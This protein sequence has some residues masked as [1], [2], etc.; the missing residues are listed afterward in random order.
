M[1]FIPNAC[2]MLKLAHNA[3][4]DLKV[5]RDDAKQEIKWKHFQML[6][7]IQEE[8]G[9]KICYKLSK[10]H[11]QFQQHKM[12]V[13]VNDAMEYL[14]KSGH[15]DFVDVEGTIK[16]IRVVDQ[17]FDLLNSR[18]PF[19]KRFKKPLF[20]HDAARWKQIINNS[21]NYLIALTDKLGMPLIKNRRKTFLLGFIVR[22]TRERD[23][24]S[25]LL[26]K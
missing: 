21:I 19:G 10:G 24:A 3:R 7:E 13:K 6:H 11:I 20:V 8:E 15:P 5:F 4:A 16:V 18:N 26:S 2:H 23:L 17:L 1:F 12:N 22:S 9:L 25:L 14:K